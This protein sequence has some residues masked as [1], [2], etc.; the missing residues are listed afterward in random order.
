M[1]YVFLAIWWLVAAPLVGFSLYAVWKTPALGSLAFLAGSTFL[2]LCT[3][4]MIREG[5]RSKA[6]LGR[7]RLGY[8][9]GL[10]LLPFSLMPLYAAYQVWELGVYTPDYSGLSRG[11]LITLLLDLLQ[12]VTGPWGPIAVMAAVGLLGPFLLIRVLVSYRR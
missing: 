11:R 2:A 7:S 8:W 3:W 12:Q 1:K 4:Q 5:Y 6:L 10:L 9:A